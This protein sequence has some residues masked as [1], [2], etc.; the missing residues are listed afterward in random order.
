MDPGEGM[1]LDF[2]GEEHLRDTIELDNRLSVGRL[3]L[4]LLAG[5]CG[6]GAAAG[7]KVPPYFSLIR[8]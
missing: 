7:L 8:S 5:S 2:V 1:R 3:A 6:P 4:L